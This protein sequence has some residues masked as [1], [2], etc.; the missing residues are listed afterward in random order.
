M[1]RKK[2]VIA[3]VGAGGK[4]ST[5]YRL[6]D[7]YAAR[8][9]K[10]IVTTS[11]HILKDENFI[12]IERAGELA[13]A[14]KEL[15]ASRPFLSVGKDEGR[16]IGSLA[17]EEIDRLRD[18]ADIVLVEADGAKRLPLK[19]P[20]EGEPQIPDSCNLVFVCAGLDCIGETLESCC[21]RYE[22]AKSLFGWEPQH[23]VSEEDLAALLC[24][25]RGG[26]KCVGEREIVFLLNKADHPRR[27]ESAYR[28][29]SCIIRCMKEKEIKNK[30]KICITSNRYP[31]K[32]FVK[33]GGSDV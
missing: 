9:K 13:H 15:F 28:V 1:Y 24:D 12:E 3:F 19:L 20:R 18:Y 27:L 5:M 8:G 16:K 26:L 4:T 23:R 7:K 33:G 2:M 31:G 22:Y 14:G 29:R 32:R 25:E 30:Y 6:A 17:G 21:L 10:V 11:T